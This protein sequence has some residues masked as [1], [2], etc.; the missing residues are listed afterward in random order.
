MTVSIVSPSA[1]AVKPR[2]Q[3]VQY[4]SRVIMNP[5]FSHGQDT[6]RLRQVWLTNPAVSSNLEAGAGP[7]F[8]G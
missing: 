5:P 3:P 7:P 6:G 1:A 4:Y 8:Q 2:R